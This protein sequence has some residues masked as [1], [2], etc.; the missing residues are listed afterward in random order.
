MDQFRPYSVCLSK[1]GKLKRKVDKTVAHRDHLHIGMTKRGAAKR[2][3]LDALSARAGSGS[4]GS[5]DHTSASPRC[6]PL[7]CSERSTPSRT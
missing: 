7:R 2:S 1:R 6:S 4:P 5:R 3:V